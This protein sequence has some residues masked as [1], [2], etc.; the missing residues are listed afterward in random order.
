MWPRLP[1]TEVMRHIAATDLV[2]GVDS[3]LT[4]LAAA[5]GV[6]TVALYG[7]TEAERTGAR[8]PNALSLQSD[9]DCSPCRSRDCVYTG[10]ADVQPACYERLPPDRVW[11]AAL[12]QY[13]RAHR[14]L[15][16]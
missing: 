16:L 8:G 5:Y 9:F 13:D 12:Q 10:A 2:I 14:L 6:P 7:S 11:A 3:G 4:H 15:S 1:L